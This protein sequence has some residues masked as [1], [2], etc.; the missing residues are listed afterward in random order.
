MHNYVEDNRKTIEMAYLQQE[1]LS[2]IEKRQINVS[3][4]Y[5]KEMRKILQNQLQSL[6]RAIRD[7]EV[8]KAFGRQKDV[9]LG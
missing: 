7:V 2:K 5:L 1:C 4:K 6:N 9:V 8:H 3:E